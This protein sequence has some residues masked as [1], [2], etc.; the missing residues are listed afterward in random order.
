MTTD[1]IDEID[2]LEADVGEYEINYL[3]SDS[4]GDRCPHCDR[5]WH[6][7]PL[8]QAVAAMYAAGQYHPDYDPAD[9]TAIIAQLEHAHG[10]PD[11]TL[12]A[13]H[14]DAAWLTA[15]RPATVPRRQRGRRRA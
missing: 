7:L 2:A 4:G 5:H 1:I 9:Y 10:Y 3:Y 12:T 13:H 14:Q 8:T 6:G 15:P 11:G